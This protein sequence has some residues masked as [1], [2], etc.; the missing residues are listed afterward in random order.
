MSGEKIVQDLMIH[1]EDYPHIPY[2]FTLNQAVII[3]REA[4]IKFEGSFEPRAL[5]FFDERY[6]LLG[7]VTLKD[8]IRGLEADILE[9]PGS[10]QRSWKEITGQELWRQAEK[11]VSQVMSPFKIFLDSNDSLVKA[12]AL[13]LQ[14]NV[15][16]I[17]V[18]TAGRVVGLIRLADLFQ[19]LSKVLLSQERPQ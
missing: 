5:L 9:K 14:A 6:Q 13:M 3:I 4:A 11:P 18:M 17:P 16:K 2:W 10:E 15:E 8:L 19:E 1:L 12:L 7:L